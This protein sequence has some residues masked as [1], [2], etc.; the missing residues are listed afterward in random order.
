MAIASRTIAALPPLA[1]LLACVTESQGPTYRI[2]ARSFANSEWSAP[3]NVGAPINT[4]ANEFNPALSPDEL[5]LYFASNRPSGFGG[6]DLWVSRRASPDSPWE[7]PANLGS[8][9]NS[10][11]NESSPNL[12]I[13]G[14]LLFFND[15]R[16]DGQGGIDVW[17][18]RR[19]DPND[20]FGWGPPVNLGPDVNTAAFDGG[21]TY[22][23]SA[24]AWVANLYFGRGR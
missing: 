2:Q 22:L 9:L 7:T 10:S 8:V 14:H 17:M 11:A 6:N 18:S 13:D 3:V 1:L 15:D 12:S 21:A 23:Q 4:A 5:S 20:D 19:A 24:E 16:P